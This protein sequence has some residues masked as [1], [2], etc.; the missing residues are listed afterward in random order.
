MHYTFKFGHR[1]FVVTEGDDC[2]VVGIYDRHKNVLASKTRLPRAESALL[3][4]LL[5][6]KF[7]PVKAPAD[8]ASKL[9]DLLG[10][11]DA[12]MVETERGRGYRLAPNA[13]S[14][15]ERLDAGDSIHSDPVRA[16]LPMWFLS[17][18][19]AD[20]PPLVL[21]EVIV[22]RHDGKH[23]VRGYSGDLD[24]Q[25]LAF[26][27]GRES[28]EIYDWLRVSIS[29]TKL[30]E[31][32]AG[33]GY[34]MRQNDDEPLLFMGRSGRGAKLTWESLP[35]GMSRRSSRNPS[36]EPNVWFF[37]SGEHEWAV[38]G[39][40][41]KRRR[42]QGG[43]E[44]CAAK[45]RKHEARLLHY[46][47]RYP[48]M[49]VHTDRLIECLWP[50][51]KPRTSRVNALRKHL[52]SL[53][54]KLEPRRQLG[55]STLI[56][57][58]A[59]RALGSVIRPSPSTYSFGGELVQMNDDRTRPLT[60]PLL[61][62]RNHFEVRESYGSMDFF[63]IVARRKSDGAVTLLGFIPS[64]DIDQQG[65]RF[66]MDDWGGGRFRDWIERESPQR[67]IYGE[68]EGVGRIHFL[69]PSDDDVGYVGPSDAVL[70]MTWLDLRGRGVEVLG[71]V[72]LL[73][74]PAP[75]GAD[76]FLA[77]VEEWRELH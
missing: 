49:E 44:V 53:A 25:S 64:G 11:P 14:V 54:E 23:F 5:R 61:L 32:S 27:G 57:S 48:G 58:Q 51:K 3:M 16:R 42:L 4:G 19:G 63:E 76:A 35:P 41:V 29:E 22:L 9:R 21:D 55:T 18:R 31:S 52:G 36:A 8:T 26:M 15:R 50:G 62:P 47:L 69:N 33:D 39:M 67:M 77:E 40:R 73:V 72:P 45:L 1:H 37:R 68:F 20:S 75:S 10:D 17:Q 70:R 38:D 71:N 24:P 7:N 12:E 74:A 6:S 46:F 43:S 28:T 34:V 2:A 66:L 59:R 13:R 65:L 30:A 56:V 60:I